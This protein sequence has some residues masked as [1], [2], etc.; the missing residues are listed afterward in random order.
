[1]FRL[2]LFFIFVVSA[3]LSF[4]AQTKQQAKPVKIV[5]LSDVQKLQL[6]KERK[7]EEDHKLLVAT[8]DKLSDAIAINDLLTVEK[9][10]KENPHQYEL[11]AF[12]KDK[13][14]DYTFTRC[15]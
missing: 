11:E 12:Y 13:I 5:I 3:Q 7:Q 15:Y 1:M 10:F 14:S 8:Y 9:L 2:I 4:G 6:E